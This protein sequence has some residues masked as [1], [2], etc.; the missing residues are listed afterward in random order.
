MAKATSTLFNDRLFLATSS[1]HIRVTPLNIW[2]FY[3]TTSVIALVV[4]QS[5]AVLLRAMKAWGG[6]GGIAPHS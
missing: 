2:F 5:K 6:G 3:Q 1:V 4:Y